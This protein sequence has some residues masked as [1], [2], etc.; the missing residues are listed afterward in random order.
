M[1]TSSSINTAPVPQAA[2]LALDRLSCDVVCRAK[3]PKHDVEAVTAAAKTA[4]SSVLVAA[5]ATAV[6]GV[7]FAFEVHSRPRRRCIEP[8]AVAAAAS[9]AAAAVAAQTVVLMLLVAVKKHALAP[10]ARH[11]LLPPPFPPRP[12]P[13]PSPLRHAQLLWDT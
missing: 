11:G 3:I 13:R 12:L 9:V 1:I 2:E 8:V 5:V 4:A 7:S 10:D 6:V